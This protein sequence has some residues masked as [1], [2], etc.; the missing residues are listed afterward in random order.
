MSIIQPNAKNQIK[1]ILDSFN[2]ASYTGRQYDAT[3]IVDFNR[4]VMTQS[5]LDR[6]YLM[7]IAFRSKESASA[8]NTIVNTDIYQLA[9]DLGKGMNCVYNRNQY[10]ICG[11]LQVG[12]GFTSYS[13][14]ACPTFLYCLE[15]DNQPVMIKS[16]R[17]V[18]NIR[19]SVIQSS[20]N[21]IFNSTDD[22]TINNSSKFVC[23][24]TF[25]EL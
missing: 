11:L 6:P 16:L 10:N 12:N 25:T 17:G 7:S 2:T 8:T 24:L 5:D 18:N 14:T 1:V 20:N 22:N 23:I 4:I 21:T 13:G 15:Q 3:Y 19:L 9:I